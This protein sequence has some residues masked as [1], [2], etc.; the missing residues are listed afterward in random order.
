MTQIMA[1][2]PIKFEIYPFNVVDYSHRHTAKFAEKPVLGAMMPLEWVGPGSETW[3]IKAK[4]FQHKFGGLDDLQ[5]LFQ[6]R[7]AGR[8]LYL[9]R[10]D[11]N[12]MGWVVI[13]SVSEKS[14]YLDGKG[15]G[16]VIEVDI[17]VKRSVAPSAGSYFSIFSGAF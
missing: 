13:E 4:I 2:G 10:G 16:K 1:L 3:T 9:M 7:Q 17:G 14:T 11:G 8:P 5:R 12:Q 15:V 6:A